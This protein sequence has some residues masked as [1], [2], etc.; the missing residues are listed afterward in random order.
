MLRG[1]RRGAAREVWLAS[2]IFNDDPAALAVADAL[3]AAAARGVRVRVV[4]DGFGSLEALGA[5]QARCA[6]AGVE[7][8][9]FR[10]LR[11]WWSWVAAEPAAPPAPA[12]C[13]WSTARSASSAAST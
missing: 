6:A 9:V 8:A 11:G 5:L 4:V 12:S 1:D 10:P 2:Y 13:V 3:C 7:L